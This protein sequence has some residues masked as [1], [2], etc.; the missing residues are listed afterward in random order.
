MNINSLDKKSLRTFLLI[1][2][3]VA[4]VLFLLPLT[5][6][7]QGAAT[8]QTALLVC[9]SLA[10]WV[11]GIGAIV[12]TKQA[13]GSLKALHLKTLGAKRYYLWAWF[14]F[15]VLSALTGLLTVLF[16]VAAFDPQFS[17]ITQSLATLPEEVPISAS[18]IIALQVGAAILFAPLLNT[19]FAVGEELGWRGFLLPQLMPLGK[20]KAIIISNIIWGLWHA[21][22]IAQGHNYPGYPVLGIF[23]MVVLTVLVGTILSWLY[24][25]TQSPWAPALAHGS[26]NAVAS[27]SLLFL[28]PGFDIA[29]GGT[30]ASVIG[31]I[32]IGVFV[33]WLA[34]S[35]KLN[36]SGKESNAA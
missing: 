14:L 4:W 23:M 2:F 24:L 3:G 21:P 13:D 17:L 15:P 28:V 27:L 31:W 29:I 12:A 20:W 16:R 35:G 19:L 22:A 33:L 25:E 30:L 6:K 1:T 11:P 7:N 9:F 26:M 18:T 5:V 34:K 10:M 8:Y 32:P 36:L